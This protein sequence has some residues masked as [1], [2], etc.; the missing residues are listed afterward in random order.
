MAE[1]LACT[2]KIPVAATP[3]TLLYQISGTF[4]GETE[5]IKAVNDAVSGF[6]TK[7]PTTQEWSV[8]CEGHLDDTDSPAL[9]VIRDAWTNKTKLTDC[10]FDATT[11][12]WTGTGSAYVRNFRISK[13]TQEFPTVSFTLEG[14]GGIV[15]A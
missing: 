1:Q 15:W 9:E 8:E 12:G 10:K 13:Q 5:M 2:V 6:L 14:T 3:T 4:S 11:T 7:A